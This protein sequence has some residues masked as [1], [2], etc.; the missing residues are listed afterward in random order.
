M[1]LPWSPRFPNDPTSFGKN[2]ALQR[3]RR[4]LVEMAKARWC[5]HEQSLQ[6]RHRA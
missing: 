5:D 1:P 4:D 3:V 6:G 2:G